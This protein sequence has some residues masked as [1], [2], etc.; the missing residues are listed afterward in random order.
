[1]HAHTSTRCSSEQ[2]PSTGVWMHPTDTILHANSC[3]R[4]NAS[5]HP[6]KQTMHCLIPPCWTRRPIHATLYRD[7]APQRKRV[8]PRHH[9]LA[10]SAYRRL[11][12]AY[13]KNNRAWTEGTWKTRWD[14]HP[15][16]TKHTC[17]IRYYIT[18]HSLVIT[19]SSSTTWFG[20]NMIQMRLH[21]H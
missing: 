10:S 8:Q 11:L 16:S 15:D 7:S 21:R 6:K 20:L 5:W 13:G 12:Y 17:W 14:I 19:G 4:D 3:Q 1:M 9:S 18:R 2:R